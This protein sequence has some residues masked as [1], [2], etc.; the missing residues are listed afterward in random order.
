MNIAIL[1]Y[2]VL[3]DINP[4]SVFFCSVLDFKTGNDGLMLEILVLVQDPAGIAA[5]EDSLVALHVVRCESR[6]P[7]ARHGNPV[8]HLELAFECHPSLNTY[9]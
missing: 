8:A 7:S 3:L 4:G 2:S 1:N 9:Q 6:V 5:V